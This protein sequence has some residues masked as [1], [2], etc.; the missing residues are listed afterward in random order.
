MP[1]MALSKEGEWLFRDVRH[2][3][4]MILIVRLQKI[5][6]NREKA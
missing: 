1:R 3:H 6:K 2:I 4:E 5:K